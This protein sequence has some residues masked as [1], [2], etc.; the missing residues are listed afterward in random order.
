MEW[1]KLSSHKPSEDLSSY[2]VTDGTIVGVAYWNGDGFID[3]CVDDFI[4]DITH[5]MPFPSLPQGNK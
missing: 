3:E 4:E 2:I 5:W 1:T